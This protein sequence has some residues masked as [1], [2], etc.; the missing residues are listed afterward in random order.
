MLAIKRIES[1]PSLDR[2][3]NRYRQ[4]WSINGRSLRLAERGPQD[5]TPVQRGFAASP[6][7]FLTLFAVSIRRLQTLLDPAREASRLEQPFPFALSVHRTKLVH[8]RLW[9][10]TAVIDFRSRSSADRRSAR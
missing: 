3:L 8:R 7:S 9:I 4:A 1:Q 6:D 10:S 2:R 5:Y